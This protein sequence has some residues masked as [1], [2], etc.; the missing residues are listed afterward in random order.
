MQLVFF[1]VERKSSQTKTL[2]RKVF[3]F[4]SEH[5]SLKFIIK[6][7]NYWVNNPLNIFQRQIW[8]YPLSQESQRVSNDRNLNEIKFHKH[9]SWDSPL[10]MVNMLY[11]NNPILNKQ[12]Q[13]QE[14]IIIFWSNWKMFTQHEWSVF[15]YTHYKL[16]VILI[17]KYCLINKTTIHYIICCM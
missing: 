4:C 15:Y 3:M 2:S 11:V 7:V 12:Q 17:S 16:F 8:I 6:N 10:E 1:T 9:I 13:C 5:F 14:R